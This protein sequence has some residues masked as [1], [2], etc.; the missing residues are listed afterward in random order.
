M[1]ALLAQVLAPVPQAQAADWMAEGL[2]PPTCSV[3]VDGSDGSALPSQQACT[4]CPLCQLSLG[5]RLVPLLGIRKGDRVAI[6]MRNRA[7]WI[8]AYLAAL[9][10]VMAASS[11]YDNSKAERVLSGK[12]APLEEKLK[13]ALVAHAEYNRKQAASVKEE[14]AAQATV[15]N[16]G[17]KA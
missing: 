15:G 11:E 4:Q 5:D 1:L 9:K 14:A 6:C 16:A 17:F 12:F 13:T 10:E 8:I 3:H 7:E 2:F